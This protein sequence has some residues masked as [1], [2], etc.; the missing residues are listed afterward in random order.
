MELLMHSF[1]L[2]NSAPLIISFYFSFVMLARFLR[3]IGPK[4][5][6]APSVPET[7]FSRAMCTIH[8]ETLSKN[9][10]IPS[11]TSFAALLRNSTFVQMGDPV[12]KVVKGEV[13][14]VVGSDLY[15]DFGH[16]FHSVCPMPFWYRKPVYPGDEVTI[17]INGI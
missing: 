12:G 15:I 11:E 8:V 1:E 16:K 17:K 14:R 5:C 10:Q 2:H 4:I 3:R 9:N 13:F 6:I 7:S